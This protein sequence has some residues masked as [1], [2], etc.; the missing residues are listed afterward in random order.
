MTARNPIT[1]IALW[2]ALAMPVAMLPLP[3]ARA[4]VFVD[5]GINVGIAPPPLPVYVQPPLPAPGYIWTPGYWAYGDDGY[6]WVPGAWVLPPVVG[7]LWTPGYWGYYGGLY[8]W[9]PGYWG[10]RVGFYGGVDYGYGY[11]GIGFVGGRWNNGAFAYNR[12]VVNFGGTHVTN[13]YNNTVIVRQ[14]TIINNTRVSYN[15]GA[16]GIHRQPT[17]QEARLDYQRRLPPTPNQDAMRRMAS[18]DRAQLVSFNHGR[19]AIPAV[20]DHAAYSSRAQMRGPGRPIGGPVERGQGPRYQPAMN[21]PQGNF[22]QPMRMEQ[23]PR[24]VRNEGPQ[25]QPPRVY[26]NPDMGRPQPGF[27]RPMRMERPPGG[28]RYE[29]P[30]RPPQRAYGNPNYRPGNRP[31]PNDHG[32]RPDRRNDGQRGG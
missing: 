22:G 27:E 17:P 21:R 13:V 25:R 20:A 31:P 15:G 26:G 18:S 6:Y 9:H 14:N 10:P 23:M 12:A 1:T 11:G 19:P 8:R 30:Q 5:V 32:H 4:G 29:G 2:T 24:E 16:Y 7:V 3:A 28:P